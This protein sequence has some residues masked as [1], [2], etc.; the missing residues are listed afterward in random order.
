MVGKFAQICIAVAISY[1]VD[2][3]LHSLLSLWSASGSAS[4]IP[5][6]A[7]LISQYFPWVLLIFLVVAIIRI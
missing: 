6:W 5:S 4:D 2:K 1:L 3:S 7:L